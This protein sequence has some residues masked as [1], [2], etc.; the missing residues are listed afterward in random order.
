MTYSFL[1]RFL[2]RILARFR[3]WNFLEAESLPRIAVDLLQAG[4]FF[5]DSIQHFSGGVDDLM[6]AECWP[7]QKLET[8]WLLAQAL[9]SQ[10]EPV[11]QLVRAHQRRKPPNQLE[12]TR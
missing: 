12:R 11:W 6:G 10:P 2:R 8:G 7:A 9:R 5:G 4:P 1:P 3:N